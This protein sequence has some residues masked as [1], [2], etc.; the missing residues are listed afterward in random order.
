[1]ALPVCLIRRHNHLTA[2]SALGL[3]P[4]KPVFPA[5]MTCPLCHA[6]DLYLFDDTV[7]DGIWFHCEAC[8]AH[9]DIITFGAQIW[10]TSTVEALNRFVALGAANA[11]ETDR[12]SGEYL[13]ALSRIKAGE[14]FWA[15][16]ATQVWNHHDDVIACRVRELG[17]DDSLESCRGLIGV[18]HHDQVAELCKGI[19]RAAPPRMREDGPSLVLPFYDLPN[20]MTGLLLIQYN[21]AFMSRRV[22]LPLS[23]NRKGKSDAGYFLLHTAMAPAPESLRNSYFIT[24]DL[25]WALTAHCTNLKS[26]LGLLPLAVAYSGPESRSAGLSWQT[27]GRAPRFFHSAH[28]TPDTVTQAANAKGYVCALPPDKIHRPPSAA[29]T[30]QR[31]AAIRRTAQTWQAAL[32]ETLKT[33]NETAAQSFVAKVGLD[34]GKL[35]DFLQRQPFI[36]KDFAGRLLSH[37]ESAPALP[38]KLQ[39]NWTVLE[40][41]GGWWSITGTHISNAQVVIEKIVHADNGAR[42]Y[43]GNILINGRSLPFADSAEKIEG[44]GLLAYAA[45]AAAGENL[46]LIYNRK[47][48]ANSHVFAMKLHQPE[49]V[50]VSGRSGWNPRTSEFCFYNY[51]IANDGAVKPV[52]Y[53]EINPQRVADFP[54]PGPIAPLTVRQLLTPS[55]ENAQLWTVFAAIT[56]DLLAPVLGRQPKATGILSPSF[57]DALAVGAALDCP[58]RKLHTAQRTN[59]AKTL[60]LAAE[61]ADWPLLASHVFDDTNVCRTAVL[62]PAGP[63]LVRMSPVTGLVATS[64]GWQLLRGPAYAVPPD[65]SA[66]RHVLP[67]YI[68][69]ALQNRMQVASLHTDLTAAILTDLADWLK[70]IYDQ[71]FN[72]PYALNKLVTEARAHEALMEAVNTG[73]EAGKLS[74]LPRPRSKEQD[75][76][77]LLRN[78]QHWWLNQRSIDRY[79][80]S[81]GGIAPNWLAIAD[82]LERDG[83]LC[84]DEAVHGMP[85]LLVR[86]DW[87]D[88]FW[89]DLHSADA[90]E[91]G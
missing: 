11:G 85:G 86:K 16:T 74:V 75:K 88:Q 50:H 91:S 64:Y 78:K 14:D 44:V 17:L 13:R 7:T 3:V 5:V 2:L 18:A 69:R 25:T 9:G 35:Q 28:I 46:L 83:L 22:F 89:G 30:L 45:N 37:V 26:G 71:T 6:P 58:T 66:M 24:D 40:R 27:L 21:E 8:R 79:C 43:V 87:C 39:R 84:G 10:N 33:S 59:V 54:E 76:S 60:A 32:Q 65:V 31:L 49:L 48:N 72:L 15:T 12:L 47:W 4:E 23:G 73:I 90:K 41:D 67:S 34:L 80:V 52:P 19:G 51:A 36:S 42:M 29:R 70:D 82:L 61:S 56:A 55:Y 81:V 20:R 1:M 53:P 63:I 68:Q 38:T 57:E 62:V 77:F